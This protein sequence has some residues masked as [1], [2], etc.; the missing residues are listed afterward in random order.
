[1]T[2]NERDC[3]RGQ[4]RGLLIDLSIEYY[5]AGRFLIMSRQQR[6]APTLPNHAVEFVLKAILERTR[7][8]KELKDQ[9]GHRLDKLPD[10]HPPAG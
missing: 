7:S 2:D 6:V 3:R 5:A 9:F 8:L 4:A 10:D 1:M